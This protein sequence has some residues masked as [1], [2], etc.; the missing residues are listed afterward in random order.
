[1]NGRLPRL[2]AAALLPG[3]VPGRQAARRDPVHHPEFAEGLS[4]RG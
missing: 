2:E 3:A 1:M 4:R